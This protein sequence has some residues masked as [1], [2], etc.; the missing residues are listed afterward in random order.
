MTQVW[1][2]LVLKLKTVT[3]KWTVWP[4]FAGVLSKTCVWMANSFDPGLTQLLLYL[5]P[6]TK[7][8][9][10]GTQVW[11]N[12]L[13]YVKIDWMAN[14]FW[15]GLTESCVASKTCNWKAN[16]FWPDLYA[17]QS[18]VLDTAQGCLK[19]T[20]GACFFVVFFFLLFFLFL[21]LFF[22][23]PALHCYQACTCLPDLS[24]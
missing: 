2:N 9:I 24:G 4:R 15:P 7:W 12:I 22:F 3:E 8:R 6:G 18:K 13:L 1:H 17:I 5:K 21:F 20:L 11:H 19:W 23:F 14:F 16:S 10:V